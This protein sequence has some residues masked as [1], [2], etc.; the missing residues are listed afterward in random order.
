[1]EFF[2]SNFVILS[3]SKIFMT[4]KLHGISGVIFVLCFQE[5]LQYQN[6]MN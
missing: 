5:A 6:S 4:F 3:L 1:M 2:L